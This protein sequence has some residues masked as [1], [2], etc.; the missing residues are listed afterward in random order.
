MTLM[1]LGVQPNGTT[2]LELSSTDPLNHPVRPAK[3]QQDYN[4]PDVITVRV[5]QGMMSSLSECRGAVSLVLLKLV[6]TLH[7]FHES[8]TGSKKNLEPNQYF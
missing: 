8:T 1:D 6:V 5:Q 7:Q 3:P 2:Q 4:M